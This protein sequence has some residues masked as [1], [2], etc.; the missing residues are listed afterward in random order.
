MRVGPMFDW[1]D[2]R[3]FLAVATMAASAA[4]LRCSA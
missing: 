3:Y 1:N 4:P 2:L